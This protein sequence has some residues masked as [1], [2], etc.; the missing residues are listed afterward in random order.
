M[1]VRMTDLLSAL[2]KFP[3]M[4]SYSRPSLIG[5][6]RYSH[7]LKIDL[8]LFFR[9]IRWVT[10]NDQFIRLS[11]EGRFGRVKYVSWIIA[12]ANQRIFLEK[13]VASDHTWV[14]ETSTLSTLSSRGQ[15][16]SGSCLRN[17]GC[18]CPNETQASPSLNH[19]IY[20]EAC[21]VQALP[22]QF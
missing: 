20:R 15:W 2:S 7:L 11:L 8:I 1:V 13:N 3:L 12:F 17:G 22:L 21:L 14:Q 9:E 16:L 19:K 5:H 4:I 18:R 10:K 6:V